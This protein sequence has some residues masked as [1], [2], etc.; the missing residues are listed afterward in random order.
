MTVTPR[1]TAIRTVG[2]S[3]S[4]EEIS[5]LIASDGAV[6]VRQFISDSVI[7]AL[8]EEVDPYLE[9][10]ISGAQAN[11]GELYEKTVGNR[12]K[13]MGNLAAISPTY[14][15]TILNHPVMHAV[16]NAFF[17]APFGDYWVNRGAV[18]Q[19]EPGEKAQGLHRDDS[20]YGITRYLGQD[21]PELMVN[22]FIALTEFREDNGAT[23]L[24][25]GSHRWKG[26]EIAGVVPQNTVGA[27]MQ[28]GDAVLYLGSVWHGAGENQSAES[29]RGLSVTMH[30]AHF[31]PMEAHVDLPRNI[32]EQMTP[33]AQKM[34]GWRS[35]CGYHGVPV[36]TVRDRR[37]E[38]ELALK[39]A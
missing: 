21:A 39:S 6:I 11:S 22:F 32:L 19:V 18:L 28:P 7:T 30:P 4:P 13:H 16:S 8:N 20:L 17:T 10:T 12:T 24:I 14:R 29:R 36:W 35:W 9:A 1:P 23:R 15:T 33:L 34:I 2:T 26:E 5:K 38:D 25:P 3:T 31:T 37:M 27:L